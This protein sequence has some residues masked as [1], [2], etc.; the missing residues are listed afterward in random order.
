M[1]TAGQI[2]AILVGGAVLS[3]TSALSIPAILDS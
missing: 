2:R 1:I 3:D